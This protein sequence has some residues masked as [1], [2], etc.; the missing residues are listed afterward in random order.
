MDLT[1]LKAK[2]WDLS[3]RLQKIQSE[4]NALAAGITSELQPVL[5]RIEELEKKE[6]KKDKK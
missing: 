5:K 2:A 6:P 4:Y 3:K 1:E